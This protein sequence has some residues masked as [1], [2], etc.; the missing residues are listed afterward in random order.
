[1]A[2][3]ADLRQRVRNY[4]YGAH[5][6]ERPFT[7]AITSSFVAADTTIDVV[8]GDDWESQDVIEVETTGEKILVLSVSTNTLTVSRAF[9]ETSAADSSGSTDRILK[10]PRWS[11]QEVDDAIG[12]SIAGLEAWGVHVWGTGTITYDSTVE[13]IQI[14]DTDVCEEFGVLALY[15]QETNT[16]IPRPLP[17]HEIAQISSAPTGWNAS[18]IGLRILDWGDLSASKPTA[19][20]TYAKIPADATELLTRQ[21]EI[22]VLG[23][24]VLLL[25]MSIAPRTS[26]PG[27]H[28]DRTVQAGQ[29]MRDARWFQG[30]YFIRARAEA[31]LLAVE[32][33]NL[34]GTVRINRAR[35]WRA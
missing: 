9:E 5:P 1:M 10:S 7:S 24:A 14:T 28:T 22:V 23:A 18:G 8:D 33:Q 26:D 15:Y 31:G 4:L 21:E 25:G 29:S 35:R 11:Q 13:F 6:N 27:A 3:V 32:R 16:L 19:Y 20:Y 17:F 34:P 2:T 12:A 30:E